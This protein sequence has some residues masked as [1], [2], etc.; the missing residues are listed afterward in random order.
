LRIFP[1]ID[2]KYDAHGVMYFK[3]EVRFLVV[4]EYSF[5]PH[6]YPSELFE[7]I[8]SSLPYDWHCNTF[9]SDMA[10]GWIVGFKELADDYIYLFDLMRGTPKAISIFNSVKD[11]MEYLQ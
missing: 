3:N 2:K 1:N 5:T 7:V 11:N 8:D 6:W 10:I 4:S 9:T